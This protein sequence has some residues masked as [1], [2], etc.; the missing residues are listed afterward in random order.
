MGYLELYPREMKIV[1][2]KVILKSGA[3]K[4]KYYMLENCGSQLKRNTTG[5]KR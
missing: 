2:A 4:S 1:F 3:K 5:V